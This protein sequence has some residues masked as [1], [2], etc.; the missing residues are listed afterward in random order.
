MDFK[1]LQKVFENDIFKVNRSLYYEMRQY[2]VAK[3]HFSTQEILTFFSQKYN[4]EEIKKCL[5]LFYVAQGKIIAAVDNDFNYDFEYVKEISGYYSTTKVETVILYNYKNPANFDLI[6]S[7]GIKLAKKSK[8]D[9]FKATL[10]VCDFVSN[11]G[12][13]LKVTKGEDGEYTVLFNGKEIAIY[14]ED[15]YSSVKYYTSYNSNNF[16]LFIK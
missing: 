7:D 10:Y 15:N 6:D 12:D 11:S 14:A 2:I 4:L 1:D 9:E 16:D 3:E 8:I 5:Y 13:S